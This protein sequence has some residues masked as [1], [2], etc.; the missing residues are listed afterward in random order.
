MIEY[1]KSHPIPLDAVPATEDITLTA[2]VDRTASDSFRTTTIINMERIN[3]TPPR[4][5]RSIH[6]SSSLGT[7]L[8]GS[9]GANSPIHGSRS[10]RNRWPFNRHQRSSSSQSVR[11][12]ATVQ[13]THS[14][15]AGSL[16]EIGYR[17]GGG[18]RWS[19]RVSENNYVS[20]NY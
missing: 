17:N 19:S 20:R 10:G 15:N 2:H 4:R 7:T 9:G 13:R 16:Q 3:R 11:S 12:H 14:A 6:V 5:S 18:G 8:D 1:F